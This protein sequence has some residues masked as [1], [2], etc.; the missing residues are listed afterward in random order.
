[1]DE[2]LLEELKE[3]YKIKIINDYGEEKY[4]DLIGERTKW[5]NEFKKVGDNVFGKNDVMFR[6][7]CRIAIIEK[8]QHLNEFE[9]LCELALLD[10]SLDVI[11]GTN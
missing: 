3:E 6:E 2:K 4:F 9:R 1:M 5:I 8:S 11:L 10:L 7:E